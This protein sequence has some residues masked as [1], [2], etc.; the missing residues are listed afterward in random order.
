M[1]P[2]MI[3]KGIDSM[4]ETETRI[5][6]VRLSCP[7]ASS[8]VDSPYPG[9]SP[10]NRGEVFIK[11]IH[12][13]YPVYH[14]LCAMRYVI[15]LRAKVKVLT[16]APGQTFIKLKRLKELF[17]VWRLHDESLCKVTVERV[18]SAKREVVEC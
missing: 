12:T 3:V 16:H 9:F 4:K 6:Q 2:D 5:A 11:M 7:F 14:Q 17:G 1:L 18:V 8:C 10:D 15:T 13:N